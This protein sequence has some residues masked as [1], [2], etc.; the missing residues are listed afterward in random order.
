MSLYSASTPPEYGLSRANW[1]FV[2]V[3]CRRFHMCCGNVMFHITPPW[4][5]PVVLPSVMWYGVQ[6]MKV[7][8]HSTALLGPGKLSGKLGCR[9]FW[10]LLSPV[11]SILGIDSA[12]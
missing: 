10:K 12:D 8:L 11:Y 6:L 7:P 2:L 9:I 5:P 1:L 4:L 3:G